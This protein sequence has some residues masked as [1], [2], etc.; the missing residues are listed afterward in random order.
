M[1]LEADV[2]GFPG[3][4]CGQIFGHVGLGPAG[5]MRIE[6][7][8]GLETHKVGAFDIDIRL[9]DRKLHALVLADRSAENNALVGVS[10]GTL[11]EPSAVTDALGRDQCAFRVKAIKDVT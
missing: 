11:D 8:C 5:Q 6:A 2:G 7:L 3:G 9:S 10:R 1:S 4:F